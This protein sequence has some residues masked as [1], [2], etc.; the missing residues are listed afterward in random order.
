MQK[1]IDHKNRELATAAAY[2][3]KKSESMRVFL[4]SI[5]KFKFQNNNSGALDDL[6]KHI[7]M[8]MNPDSDWDNFRLHFE[9]VHPNYF[10]NLKKKHPTLTKNELRLC[11]YLIMNLSNKEIALLLYIS[12]DTVQKAKYRLKKKLSLSSNDNL[13]DYLLT[14]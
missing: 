3:I 8:Q 2:T 14:I 7:E 5:D 11:S 12:A 10:K 6:R 9:E 13:F 1:E 4:D